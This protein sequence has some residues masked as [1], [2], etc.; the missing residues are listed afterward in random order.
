L[1]FVRKDKVRSC[2]IIGSEGTLEWN[3][4][5]GEVHKDIGSG[6]QEIVGSGPWD[7]D[8]DSY[9]MEWENFLDS[10]TNKTV[11]SNVLQNAILTLRVI[12][13]CEESDSRGCRVFLNHHGGGI[14]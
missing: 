6:K 3:G 5:T 14:S 7:S 4:L 8:V 9:R 13:A 10:I 12:E 11:P 2:T 1:D